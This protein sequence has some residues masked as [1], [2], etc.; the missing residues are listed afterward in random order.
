MQVSLQMGCRGVLVGG[1]PEPLR[2]S[3]KTHLGVK[4]CQEGQMSI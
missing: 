3:Y 1:T 4:P 2:G